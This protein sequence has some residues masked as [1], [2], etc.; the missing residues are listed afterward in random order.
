MLI[1]ML[2]IIIITIIIIIF[3]FFFIIIINNNN[4][5]ISSC[6]YAPLV[7][8]DQMGIKGKWT[9]V[10][11]HP[12]PLF[13]ILSIQDHILCWTYLIYIGQHIFLGEKGHC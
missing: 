2:I 6:Q 1:I 10:N 5:S 9:K 12:F 8:P 3:F 7:H 11:G 13:S 4:I